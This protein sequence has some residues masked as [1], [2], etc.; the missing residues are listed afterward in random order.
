MATEER[1]VL[2]AQPSTSWVE[3]PGDGSAAIR[4]YLCQPTLPD[5]PAGAV[6]VVPSVFGLNRYVEDVC[7]R[8]ARAGFA[9]LGVDFY[10]RGDG[11]GDLSSFQG[12][13]AQ[14]ERIPDNRA[15]G[16]CVGAASWLAEQTFVRPRGVGILGFCVGGLYAYLSACDS[17]RFRAVVNF[18]GLVRYARL[19][20]NKPVDPLDRV[21][22]LKA[23]MLGH[24]GDLDGW[25]TPEF[26][27]EFR[28]SLVQQGKVFEL[29]EYPGA[30]HAFHEDE[31][32]D[33]FR[34]VAAATAWERSL[35]FLRWY[36]EGR[37]GYEASRHL[38]TKP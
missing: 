15:V 12:I 38:P 13:V 33:A 6:V 4:G 35:V 36:L 30:P 29:Y 16:D 28:R 27:A 20:A 22:D 24:F 26:V 11:P 23:P 32:V 14:L 7:E 8:L 2:A 10:S 3:F 37:H 25:A 1:F 18:Y 19:S 17:D 34:P 31:R 5:E 21:P 9:A